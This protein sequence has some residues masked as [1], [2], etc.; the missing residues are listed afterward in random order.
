MAARKRK[1]ALTET[2]KDKIKVS[3]IGLRLFDHVQGKIEMTPT[4]ISAAN[5]LLKKLVP[6]LS[7]TEVTGKDGGA[8]EYA[9]IVRVIVEPG[10]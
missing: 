3:I 5:I 4:Q 7:S 10:K 6:D 2:W 9:K 8:I 1:I